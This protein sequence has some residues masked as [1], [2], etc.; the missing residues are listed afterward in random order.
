MKNG[1]SVA[2]PGAIIF[3][4][5]G[6]IIDSKELVESFWIEKFRQFNLDVPKENFEE[7]FHGRPARLIIDQEFP[8]LSEAQR[9]VMEREIKDY[10]SSVEEFDLIPGIEIFLRRCKKEDIPI[11]LV[12]SALP[13]KVNVMKKS[14]GFDPGFVT[15]VTANRVENGKPDPECYNLALREMGIAPNNAVVFE[16]SVSGVQAAAGS[17]ATV[18][19]VNEPHMHASLKQN[20]AS[21]TIKNF[22]QAIIDSD[23][24]SI[25]FTST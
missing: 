22:T 9:T 3:D 17:N 18:I 19:G 10:D 21:N 25:H 8:S 14:L 20:G 12:T 6:V 2:I 24:S 15:E 23:E 13:P 1:F 16:D 7:R 4:M 5:D 11:A